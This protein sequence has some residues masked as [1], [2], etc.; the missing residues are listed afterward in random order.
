MSKPKGGRS[1]A[2][3]KTKKRKTAAVRANEMRRDGAVEPLLEYWRLA[4]KG[5]CL[6]PSLRKE[7]ED[8]KGKIAVLIGKSKQTVKNMYLYGVGETNVW[9]KII[10]HIKPKVT[11]KDVIKLYDSFPYIQDQLDKLSPEQVRIYH[12][13][14]KLSE[15]ELR[16][17]N[18]LI[19][20][21]IEV[22]KA[23][24]VGN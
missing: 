11:Q 3:K 4:L 2:S 1:T 19:E 6:D 14:N 15:D 18:R 8:R 17:V 22:N 9:L 10:D 24:E 16:L 20:V 5:Y 13:I 21:G 23:A 12:N 7:R